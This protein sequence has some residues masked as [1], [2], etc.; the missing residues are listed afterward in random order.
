MPV[1]QLL[2]IKFMLNTVIR[3]LDEAIAASGQ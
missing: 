2:A 3:W 1:S